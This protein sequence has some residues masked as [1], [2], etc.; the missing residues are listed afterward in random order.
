MNEA[1]AATFS[2]SFGPITMFDN[3]A[4]FMSASKWLVIG[5]RLMLSSL[6]SLLVALRQPY[7]CGC[8]SPSCVKA[9]S[10]SPWFLQYVRMVEMY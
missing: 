7:T 2:P 6:S 10:E 4:S 3:A 9:G 1:A 5:V 8:G